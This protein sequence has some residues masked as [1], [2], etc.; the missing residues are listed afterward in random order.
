M[1]SS[2]LKMVGA[3]VM[4]LGVAGTGLVAA[5]NARTA[6][7][8]ELPAAK[9]EAPARIAVAAPQAGAGPLQAQ[10]EALLGGRAEDWSIM[11]YALDSQRT[12]FAVNATDVRIPASNNKVFSAI[13][14]LDVLGPGYRFPT[15]VLAAGPIENGVL[16]GD[17]VL[18]GSGD[19]AFGYPEYDKD[20]MK[21]PKAM[22]EALRR[23]GVR[24]VEG[25]V[26][27][28]ASI[29]DERNYGP[30]WPT[31]TGNG[32]AMYAPTVS[33]LPFAR[34]L[35]WVSIRPGEGRG[36]VVTQPDVPEI[37]VLWTVK[38]GRGYAVRKPDQDT[39][40]VRGGPSG[41]GTR[42]PIGVA[43]ASLL[44]GG[45]LRQALREAG[46]EVRGAVREGKTPEGAKLLHRHY[47]IPLVEMVPQLN[48]HSDN[49]FA[50]H[51]WKAAATEA[52]GKGSYDRGPQASA[53]FFHDRA[54]VPWGS[55]WQADGSGLSSQNRASAHS[56]VSAL[57][58]AH[59]RPWSKAFHES[60]AVAADPQGTMR[61]LFAG[62][63]AAG[64]LHAKTGYIRRVRTLSGYV[65]TKNG[66]LVVFSFL[67]NGP[68]TGG[69]RNVQTQLGT[70]LADFAG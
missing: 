41:P 61:R 25:G 30:D 62:T 29:H 69:A 22:A 15:D 12:L 1:K 40:R 56:L 34:N 60:M 55:L 9:A 51:L 3:S 57:V 32:A 13:W 19:P 63:S 50:E 52:T 24:V 27:A 68:N 28:D 7:P 43:D 37:P 38:S 6:A 46:V 49:F 54:G 18:R 66:E 8:E 53:A 2:S 42:Y 39:I 10:A 14:A 36:G 33:G 23:R 70:L 11:A 45:A 17:V 26:I 44:A 20:P 67:Y 31:D 21:A 59:Q 4:A 65:K 5:R 35:L 58:Y 16:K 48:R 47:S 64:N